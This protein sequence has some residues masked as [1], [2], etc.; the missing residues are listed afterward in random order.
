MNYF[1]IFRKKLNDNKV[2]GD[3][4]VEL[5]IP[6]IA[7]KEMLDSKLKAMEKMIERNTLNLQEIKLDYEKWWVKMRRKYGL[8]TD[9]LHYDNGSFFEWK[10]KGSDW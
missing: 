7:E 3:R 8:T 2:V 5:D 6:D 9:N 1:D 4:L 10:E